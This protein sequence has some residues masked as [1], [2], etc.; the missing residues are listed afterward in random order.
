[1]QLFLSYF[2][3]FLLASS[4]AF[5]VISPRSARFFNISK[6]PLR[7]CFDARKRISIQ[8]IMMTNIP[9]STS[10]IYGTI[11]LITSLKKLFMI[12]VFCLIINI[13]MKLY[14]IFCFLKGVTI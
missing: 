1:F 6:E 8:I 7:G 2:F 12:F 13:Y 4:Y 11:I 10:R 9:V 3:C 14:F 5:F